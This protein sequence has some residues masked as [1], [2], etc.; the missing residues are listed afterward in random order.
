MRYAIERRKEVFALEQTRQVKIAYLGGGSRGWAWKL[1]SDL[2]NEPAIM[3]SVYLYD[4][5]R[6][7]AKANEMIGNRIPKDCPGANPIN[8]IA[9][10][11]MEQA[12]TGADFV[13]IS[14]LP[15][16][17]D[18][19]ESDVHT[20]EQYG[21][22]QSVGDSTGPGGIIRA[23]R[24]LPMMEEFARNIKQYCPN[25]WVINYTNPMSLSVGMMYRTFPEI[26]AFG[27]CHEVFGTQ[28]F[29]AGVVSQDTG[30]QDIPRQEIKVNVM[31]INHFTWLTKVNYKG[32]DLFP[33][34]FEYCKKHHG[35]GTS[36]YQPENPFTCGERV[37]MDLFL[38]YG[39]IAAAG[40]RHLAEFCPGDW[41][42]KDPETVSNWRFCLTGVAYRKKELKK[43]LE[44]SRKLVSG[45]QK[46][47][48]QP[49]GEEGVVQMKAILG[50]GDLVTNVNLPNRG[51][52]QNLP[53]GAIVETNALF[54]A[55]SVT[56]V[57]AGKM[58]AGPLGLTM[59][60]VSNQELVL[61]AAQS[62]SL[63]PAFEAFCKDPLVRLPLEE[64]RRLFDQ[65]VANTKQYLGDYQ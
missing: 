43:R 12:L 7:A 2:A 54:T 21:I 46:F 4:I 11:T 63:E 24:T 37:K 38:R 14:I 57:L 16:T 1:M 53:L 56:P 9:A 59:P 17:F 31:G 47:R 55:D 64:S 23:L 61:G 65:M 48:L 50:L 52:I 15:G 6:E 33:I 32:I 49:S 8:Y 45:E 25:A 13:V 19:M 3:G 42:L 35:I 44:E 28:Q 18:E 30:V 39:S 41:Y 5:D 36:T 29:L 62:R 10:D 22:Y 27:C 40:D 34:Y 58:P 51:Q 20:P 60:V 26:K